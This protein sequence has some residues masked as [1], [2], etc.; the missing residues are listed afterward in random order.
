M[1][2]TIGPP[3]LSP[4]APP[5]DPTAPEAPPSPD[6]AII[7]KRL[8]ADIERVLVETFEN[9]AREQGAALTTFA[10]MVA[11]NLL[12]AIE[13]GDSNLTDE[14]KDQ[15]RLLAHIAELKLTPVMWQTVENILS[16]VLRVVIT[17]VVSM[18]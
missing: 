2:D 1:S 8:G 11:A 14:A 13:A 3:K 4:P 15:L 18:I 16:L 6:L 17:T 5:L 10:K 12:G 7:G 9:V